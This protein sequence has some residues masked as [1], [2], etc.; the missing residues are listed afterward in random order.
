M[1]EQEQQQYSASASEPVRAG[2]ASELALRRVLIT[3][4][5]GLIGTALASALQRD[6]CEL[7]RGSYRGGSWAFSNLQ[8]GT[9]V[10]ELGGL[11][12]V[13]NLAGENISARWTAAKKR[14][15]RASRVE[16]TRSLCT[17]L[18]QLEQPPRL[19]VSASA[20]GYYGDHGDEVLDEQSPPGSG[21][22]AEVCQEWEAATAAA[23]SAGISVVCPRFGVVLSAA[24]GALAKMLPAAR[25]GLAGPLGSGAQYMSWVSLEDAIGALRHILDTPGL[26]GAVNITAPEPVTNAELMRTLAEVLG[27]RLGPRTPAAVIRLAL[28]EMGQALLLGSQRVLPTRLLS[29][30]FRFQHGTLAEALQAELA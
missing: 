17:L 8:R 11:D 4:A 20:T 15:I 9:T 22:L 5:S 21:F 6:G 16:G 26:T 30:G 24:G 7:V 1:D 10:K 3:G 25:L 27:K 12:A 2:D 18:A 19:L 29:S 13:I 14:A 28:G 23:Q